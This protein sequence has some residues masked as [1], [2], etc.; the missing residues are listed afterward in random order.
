MACQLKV[1]F[2]VI[3]IE[4]GW[5]VPAISS[6]YV[7][8]LVAV[9]RGDGIGAVA[10]LEVL[11]FGEVLYHSLADGLGLTLRDVLVEVE[12]ATCHFDL[13]I[14]TEVGAGTCDDILTKWVDDSDVERVIG[15]PLTYKPV[16][17]VVLAGTGGIVA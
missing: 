6:A 4:D 7:G 5:L 11:G 10:E 16:K 3:V 12:H 2:L 1:V 14:G 17:A 13:G 15:C 8:Y 9:L